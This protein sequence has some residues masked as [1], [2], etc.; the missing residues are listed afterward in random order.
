MEEVLSFVYK[1]IRKKMKCESTRTRWKNAW[2]K[3]VDLFDKSVY[4]S[5]R[6]VFRVQSYT[7][8]LGKR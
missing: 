8:L 7:Q 2:W 6:D 3:K 5:V 4:L 1:R